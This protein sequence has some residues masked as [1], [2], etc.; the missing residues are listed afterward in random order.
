MSARTEA[1]HESIIT[2]EVLHR[3]TSERVKD[4]INDI[5]RRIKN[6][7]ICRRLL[8]QVMPGTTDNDAE[9]IPTFLWIMFGTSGRN[10]QP[11]NPEFPYPGNCRE[12]SLMDFERLLRERYPT[13]ASYM[14]LRRIFKALKLHKLVTNVRLRH[15]DTA[16]GKWTSTSYYRF[17][18]ENWRVFLALTSKTP[19]FKTGKKRKPKSGNLD[20]LVKKAHKVK[21]KKAEKALPEPLVFQAEP[22][23]EVNP[24]YSFQKGE[25]PGVPGLV[26]SDRLG[27]A[28]EDSQ[29]V[30]LPAAQKKEPASPAVEICE[31]LSQKEASSKIKARMEQEGPSYNPDPTEPGRQ[32]LL[33]AVLEVQVN[34]GKLDANWKNSL[35][36]QEPVIEGLPDLTLKPRIPDCTVLVPDEQSDTSGIWPHEGALIRLSPA[37]ITF[38]GL[39]ERVAGCPFRADDWRQFERLVHRKASDPMRMTPS[40][41]VALIRAFPDIGSAITEN[42][43]GKAYNH[44][45]LLPEIFNADRQQH[46]V[47]LS[48]FHARVRADKLDRYLPFLHCDEASAKALLSPGNA[49]KLLFHWD[50]LWAA[51]CECTGALGRMDRSHLA[52]ISEPNTCQA[53]QTLEALDRGVRC[54]ASVLRGLHSPCDVSGELTPL[55]Y[56]QHAP[57]GVHSLLPATRQKLHQLMVKLYVAAPHIWC[58]LECWMGAKAFAAA[59]SVRDIAAFRATAHKRVSEMVTERWQEPYTNRD[60]HSL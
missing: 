35:Y 22:C 25:G 54:A 13:T 52:S 56:I 16:T 11:E 31:F 36:V 21:V 7:V 42:V 2:L 19:K 59:M 10:R 51:L 18:T 57:Q 5:L 48:A 3:L 14:Q 23:G 26:D 20:R 34:E 28:T 12:M 55:A 6:G 27:A 32:V 4:D 37:D 43:D 33:E 9:F 60:P 38:G 30:A 50:E 53:P 15:H 29:L 17:N 8:K 58:D 49:G 46:A 39:A 1:P 41:F 24:M 47:E 40:R 45:T 44:A